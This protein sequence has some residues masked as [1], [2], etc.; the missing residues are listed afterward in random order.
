MDN[1]YTLSPLASISSHYQDRN[2]YACQNYED[3]RF[4][5]LSG[6]L[7]ED[8]SLIGTRLKS[9]HQEVTCL[10]RTK[11]TVLCTTQDELSNVLDAS[12]KSRISAL[13]HPPSQTKTEASSNK[14]ANELYGFYLPTRSSARRRQVHRENT[15]KV[16][17]RG[18]VEHRTFSGPVAKR[19][20]EHAFGGDEKTW[21]HI[22]EEMEDWKQRTKRGNA[23]WIRGRK[24][25]PPLK[26]M[27]Q[28][29]MKSIGFRKEERS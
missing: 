8:T 26:Q 15:A 17:H 1:V 3:E 4:F 21:N 20:E 10:G 9:Q 28:R 6:Q 18:A 5:G 27:M 2:S 14:S 22:A 11:P 12:P 16:G 13:A 23:S 24:D 29:I 19:L 25:A 7:R